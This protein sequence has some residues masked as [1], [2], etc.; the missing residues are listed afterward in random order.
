MI[1]SALHRCWRARDY[2]AE[3]ATGL[4]V[5]LRHRPAFNLP[6]R[7]I[8][9]WRLLLSNSITAEDYYLFALDRHD[10]PW[11]RKR[12]FLGQMERRRWQ[13]QL[14]VGLYG[15]FTH[16]KLITKRFLAHA[17]LPVPQLA[18]VIGR[19]GRAETGQPLSTPDELRHWLGDAAP[20]PVVFKPVLGSRGDG[21][22]ILGERGAARARWHRV[23]GQSIDVDGIVNHVFRGRGD[24][25]VLVEERLHPHPEL[26]VFSADVLHTA[27]ILTTLDGDA[28]VIAA[29][30]RI[31]LGDASVDNFSKGNLAAPI[32][33]AT[34]G[35][36]RAV[37][38][39]QRA[40]RLVEHP[41]TGA[42]IEGRKVPDWDRTVA[43][44]RIAA[45][46]TPFNPVQ[47][48]DVAFTS[49]GPVIVEA[50]G[51][52]DLGVTQLAP[53][54]GLLGTE[55]RGYLKSRQLRA[56]FGLGLGD[57]VGA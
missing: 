27:R 36:G 32:D 25:Y 44:L 2:A 4:A 47:G 56:L 3:V 23:P 40:A 17:G 18:A 30:L 35:L 37:Y 51:R 28:Q 6:R 34:G 54:L 11:A 31:G 39:R 22:L 5:H 52:W 42:R 10:L 12:E 29:A 7:V 43:M 50:N 38:K 9:Q 21:V 26:T 33:L 15:F 24:P 41:V 14:S 13:E 8:E 49:S 46:A 1:R 16:D 53:D 57:P 20:E 19:S 45:L 48:W 55:L